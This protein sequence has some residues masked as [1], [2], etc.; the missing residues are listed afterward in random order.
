MQ[1]FKSRRIWTA[2]FGLVVLLL[3]SVNPE[4][5]QHLNIIAPALVAIVGIL[6]GGFSAED[7]AA[8]VQGVPAQYGKYAAEKVTPKSKTL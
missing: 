6:I 8:R 1:V 7:V 3:S 4:L 2:L 5:E